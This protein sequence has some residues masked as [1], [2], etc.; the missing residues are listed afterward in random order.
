MANEVSIT[1][2]ADPSAAEAGFKK[3]KSGFQSVKDSIVKNR[4]AIGVGLVAMGAGI[5]AL[6]KNQQ[7]LTES[8]LKLANATGMSEKEIRGMATSLSNA[9][10]PLDEALG[11][12][13][14]GAQQGLKSADSLKQYAA[15]WDT[16]ADATG[17]SSEALAKSGAA[18]AAVGVEVGNESELLGAFGL[19]T[20]ESTQSVQ[21]FLNSVSLLAPELSDVGISVDEAAVIMTAMEREMG[22]VGRTARTEFKEALEQSETGLAGVLEQLGL[23]EDQFA[24]YQTKLEASTGVMGENADALASTKTTMDKLKSSMSDLMFAN[25]ALIE[26]ASMLAPLFLAAGPIVA[27]FSGIMGILTPALN[28]AKVAFIGLN[29][30]MGVITLVVLGITAAIAAGIL[31]WK[32]WDTVIKVV[33]ETVNRVGNF[34]IDMFNKITFVQRKFITVF[35]EG[36]QALLS[37][38][39]KLPGV[40]DKFDGLADTVQLVI[41]KV[42]SGIPNFELS[43]SAMGDMADGAVSTADEF[44]R[45]AVNTDKIG[46]ALDKNTPKIDA[47]A[48]SYI[49]LS[50]SL[51]LAAEGAVDFDSVAISATASAALMKQLENNET[52]AASEAKLAQ[53]KSDIRWK[54]LQDANAARAQ[55]EIDLANTQYKK[56]LA[57][58]EMQTAFDGMTKNMLFNASA[59][60]KAWG[61]L[62]GNAERVLEN[63]AKVMETSTQDI[64]AD[65]ADM[66]G[67]GETWKDLL[68][69]LS[70][71]GVINLE[72]LA[73]GFF[74]LGEAVGD[75][76][77]EFD[78]IDARFAEMTDRMSFNFSTQG[79]N[80]KTLG[81][82]AERVILAMSAQTGMAADDIK[83]AFAK[84]QEPGETWKE[85]LLRL[86]D[87]GFKFGEGLVFNLAEIT[88]ALLKVKTGAEDVGKAMAAADVGKAATAPPMLKSGYRANPVGSSFDTGGFKKFSEEERVKARMDWSSLSQQQLQQMAKSSTASVRWAA[89]L[90]RWKRGS[91]AS[92]FRPGNVLTPESLSWS[93]FEA[94]KLARGGIVR[95]PT[96]AML[97]ESGPE[98]VVPL[99]RGGGA[100]MTV[101]LV[102]N[103]DINGMDDFEQKVTSVIRDA[104][105]GGGFSGVLA[106][107]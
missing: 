12:M 71:E 41:D 2:T 19:I 56:N 26:K 24:T 16:V 48:Q 106:R 46:S 18:L 57:V 91:G 32:N 47:A 68:L 66:Q 43:T 17:L 73:D 37:V 95:R 49:S 105:L 44:D 80:W 94:A 67:E 81:G 35:L 54:D 8:T 65:F 5:E 23:S 51:A 98:A 92:V 78:R 38:A 27:G 88:A 22:K 103:G 89:S 25:G 62:G 20:R 102:I 77:D 45:V 101:N 7:V 63:I 21:D 70:T 33:K 42:N 1:I 4:K 39:A 64:I 76:G 29:L 50:D 69:R 107:A 14:L 36:V 55:E 13:K 99:G 30:S 11:L 96:L 34:L 100:G 104:V 97:G 86:D 79:Q 90:E 15:F 9:T 6:A 60:G 74:E 58:L 82:T 31:I 52:L 84:M 72:D 40:G 28:A 10:F 3:V 83:T 53:M 75:T 59:Q 93:Q 61:D 87:I 85:L